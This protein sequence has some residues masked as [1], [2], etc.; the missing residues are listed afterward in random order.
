MQS[1]LITTGVVCIIAAIV[2]GGLK[3]LGIEVP[4]LDSF[5]RQ[6]LLGIFGIG[7]VVAGNSYGSSPDP[8][9]QPSGYPGNTAGTSQPASDVKGDDNDPNTPPVAAI[10]C[11]QPG[12]ISDGAPCAARPPSAPVQSEQPAPQPVPTVAPPPP[13][14]DSPAIPAP[15]QRA[16]LREEIE[17]NAGHF[18]EA[19]RSRIRDAHFL[20]N[21]IGECMQLHNQLNTM[22]APGNDFESAVKKLLPFQTDEMRLEQFRDQMSQNF[23]QKNAV[24]ES[25]IAQA[26]QRNC[27]A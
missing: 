21:G 26:M 20:T 1:T 27:A 9:S 6:A 23:A 8:T 25:L 14:V 3:A 18:D 19:I 13:V 16:A 15:D 24:I 10:Q 5:A 2:G 22:A 4:K 11:T 7:L 17:A 12:N